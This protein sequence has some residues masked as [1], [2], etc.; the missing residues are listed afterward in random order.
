MS[1]Q[2]LAALY[3]ELMQD[4]PYDEWVSFTEKMLE[5]PVTA[6]L[7]VGCGTG[8]ITRRLSQKGYQMTGVDLSEEMLIEAA[9]DPSVET[10]HIQWIKQDMREL[11]GFNDQALI[12]SYCDVL[13]YITEKEDVLKAFRAIHQSL[14][15]DGQ[16]MFDV[17]SLAHVQS[18]SDHIYSE[19]QDD[20]SY[21]WFCDRGQA[22]GEM[23]HDMTFFIKEGHCYQRYDESHHQ[24]TYSM[25]TYTDLLKQA[26]F[27]DVR[28]YK[29]FETDP[30]TLADE[31]HSERL[32]FIA[33]K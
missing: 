4:A 26:G 2:H 11:A 18:M 9:N 27:N 14:A 24:R 16:F 7:D 5:T 15:R 6:I 30:I 23:F 13:N 17:H 28:V 25:A 3:D 20:Y 1:Y 8:Q 21:I 29:D 31:H 10:S 33:K 22:E 32:F 12:V 19:V